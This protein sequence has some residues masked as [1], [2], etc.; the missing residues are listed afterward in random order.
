MQTLATKR[1]ILQTAGYTY[2]F[3]RQIYINRSARKAFSVEFV[4]DHSETELEARIH[5]HHTDSGWRFYFNS[6]PSAAV[7]Q[8]LS[9]SL[10]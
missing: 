4:E 6:P 9:A 5:E 1:Q 3:D 10:Q 2:K 8:E 7:Q